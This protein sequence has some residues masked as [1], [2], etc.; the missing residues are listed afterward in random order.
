MNLQLSVPKC[1]LSV[2][3]CGVLK[4]HTSSHISIIAA[5]LGNQIIPPSIE[6]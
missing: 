1:L 3:L 6:H 5:I 2:K 4:A